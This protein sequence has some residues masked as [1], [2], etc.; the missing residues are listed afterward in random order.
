MQGKVKGNVYLRKAQ[1][2]LLSNPPIQLSQNTVSAKLF[3]TKQLVRRSMRDNPQLSEDEKIKKC[4]GYLEKGIENV[5]STSDKEVI[6]GIEGN[7]AKCYFEIFDMLVLK[8][9]EDFRM[10]SRTKRPPLDRLNCALS[11]LYTIA[12]S[13]FASAL[14]SVGL[15]SC[16][17]YYH[18]LRSGRSSLACDMVEEIR[19]IVERIVLTMINL[20]Q[21][22]KDDFETQVSGAVF[23]TDDGRKKM[24]TAWQEKK[25]TVILHPYINEKIQLGLLPYVQSSL[26]AK[27]IRG[28]IAEYPSFLQ[29]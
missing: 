18:S 19:C 14:E 28:D 7:C 27:Y 1:F 17:G 25:K 5:Y 13:S 12:T 16:C 8:Q 29:K 10:T 24:I 9:K 15:D 26:L 6:M 22:T 3:N 20:R 21:L 23:L 2:E 11:F 4:I